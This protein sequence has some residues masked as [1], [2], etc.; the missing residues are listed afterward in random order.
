[1]TDY[2]ELCERLVLNDRE[3]YLPLLGE[4]ATAIEALQA[5][6]AEYR[7]TLKAIASECVVPVGTD[8]QMYSRWRNLATK[9]VDLARAALE[10]E[11]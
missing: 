3:I 4:A 6:V 8:K 2:R 9:R 1:M 7:A 10:Q 11:Q 5:E